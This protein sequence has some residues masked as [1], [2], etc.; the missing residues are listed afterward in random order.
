MDT[1]HD[2]MRNFKGEVHKTNE[3]G[4][5]ASTSMASGMAR[6]Y[7]QGSTTGGGG[8]GGGKGRGRGRGM[9]DGNAEHKRRRLRVDEL[10]N[11]E[12]RK[13]K[14]RVLHRLMIS[15][16]SEGL[17]DA[18]LNL[19]PPRVRQLEAPPA[20]AGGAPTHGLF[21]GH[22]RRAQLGKAWGKK[23]AQK[24]QDRYN[25]KSALLSSTAPAPEDP[26]AGNLVP[27]EQL[28][29]DDDDFDAP[30]MAVAV[31][32][33]GVAS[34]PGGATEPKIEGI[35][36]GIMGGTAE[37]RAE[38]KNKKRKRRDREEEDAVD[39]VSSF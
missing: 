17:H 21:A 1:L 39:E 6:N 13:E 10:G 3:T 27:I 30:E 37:Q 32:A 4:H 22:S 35:V 12:A 2:T 23:T 34:L 24:T 31:P 11:T 26:A 28:G 36:D 8:G 25:V 14:M 15:E 19:E 29:D 18:I 5:Q 16:D 20:E 33:G 9:M 7:G 38:Q